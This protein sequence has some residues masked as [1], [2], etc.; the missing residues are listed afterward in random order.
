MV[1]EFRSE[2]PASAPSKAPEQRPVARR[3]YSD[4]REQ[5]SVSHCSLV[6]A[7]T[8]DEVLHTA[9]EHAIAAHGE[10]PGPELKEAVRK[11]L[12]DV[13]AGDVTLA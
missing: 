5:P 11:S 6:I 10:K 2:S 9:Y 13:P 4:C 7:G 8:E 1:P 12:R 3:V